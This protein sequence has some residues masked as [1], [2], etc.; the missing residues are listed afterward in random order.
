MLHLGG[1]SLSVADLFANAFVAPA[2]PPFSLL[3]GVSLHTLLLGAL[4]VFIGTLAEPL[5]AV[6]PTHD[7][8]L[9]CH[10]LLNF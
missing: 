10:I 2:V 7:N 6:Q 5:L 4:Q 1:C 8:R 9:H 3:D